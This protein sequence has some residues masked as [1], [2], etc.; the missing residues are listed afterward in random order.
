MSLASRICSRSKSLRSDPFM[1]ASSSFRACRTTQPTASSLLR[2][3]TSHG[4]RKPRASVSSHWT[5]C[6]LQS[7]SP[8]HS[9]GSHG[10]PDTTQT[11][12][13]ACCVAQSRQTTPSLS[14]SIIRTILGSPSSCTMKWNTTRAVT[15]INTCTSGRVITSATV[16]PV[17]SRTGPPKTL[18][19]LQTQSTV[20]ALTGDLR[21]IQLLAS[22]AT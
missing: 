6:A 20:L 7:V 3:T 11:R 9:F 12:L 18:K 8:V 5:F 4:L 14:R 21:Q 15:Q 1:A 13:K 10:T 16:R 19:H 17:C 22:A 2:V